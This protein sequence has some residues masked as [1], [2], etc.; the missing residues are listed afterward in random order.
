MNSDEKYFT[1]AGERIARNAEA[2]EKLAGMYQTVAAARPVASPGKSDKP[3]SS[4]PM[5]PS[6][7]AVMTNADVIDLRKAGLDD[8]NLIAAIKDA[9]AAQF[10]LSPAAL[11]ALLA[12]KIS[13]RV[14]AAMR[15]R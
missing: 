12:A 13:N 6:S 5:K 8:D 1:E 14:I 10:D 9:P 7:S 11:K 15:T 4:S 2:Y 3:S